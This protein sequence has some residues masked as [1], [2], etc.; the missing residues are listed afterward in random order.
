MKCIMSNLDP[1]TES[2][3]TMSHQISTKTTTKFRRP[4]KRRRMLSNR[5][6]SIFRIEFDLRHLQRMPTKATKKRQMMTMCSTMSEKSCQFR[7]SVTIGV[8]L[9]RMAAAT[10]RLRSCLIFQIQVCLNF[11]NN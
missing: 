3:T 10:A 6:K 2:K 8:N 5:R 1:A 9:R 11:M 4:T 7:P